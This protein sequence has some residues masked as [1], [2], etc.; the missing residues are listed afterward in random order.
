MKS[1]LLLDD[2]FSLEL[3]SLPPIKE[4]LRPL[5]NLRSGWFE[6]LE[7]IILVI[8]IYTLVNLATIRFIVDGAS[9]YPTFETGQYLIINRLNY[10]LSTPQRGDVVVFHLPNNT[11]RDFIKRVIGLPGETIEFRDT[12]VYING[13]PLNEPYINEPCAEDMCADGIMQLGEGEY[14]VMGDN[15]NQSADSRFF[16]PIGLDLIVGEA[17]LRY[18]PFSDFT[19]LHRIGLEDE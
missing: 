17:T 2:C 3:F 19:W 5:L 7:R 18:Y 15:R 1:G 10:T 8:A 9:M 11:R 12:Q 4:K 16:G 14:F 6:L 13:E